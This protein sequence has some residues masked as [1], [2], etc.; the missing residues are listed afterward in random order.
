MV[1]KAK[2]NKGARKRFKMLAKKIKRYRAGKG[3]LLASKTRKRK[4]NLRR[5]STVST[6]DAWMM[7]RLLP[8]G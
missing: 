7:R 8:Y 3:H 5:R 1:N 2:T 4:R 6:P